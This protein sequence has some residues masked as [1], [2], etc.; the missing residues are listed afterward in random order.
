MK[1]EKETMKNTVN[2]IEEKMPNVRKSIEAIKA[3]SESLGHKEDDLDDVINDT[4]DQ[5]VALLEQRR[6][7]LLNQLHFRVASKR[8]KLDVQLKALED[9]MSE[10]ISSC[11]YVDKAIENATSTQLLLVRKQVEM[12]CYISNVNRIFSRLVRG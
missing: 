11:E 9:N 6:T 2:G 5:L 8:E 12:Q 7:C 10:V 4:F 1:T 3:T